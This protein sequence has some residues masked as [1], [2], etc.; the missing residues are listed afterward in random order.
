MHGW[1]QSYV[2]LGE[3]HFVSTIYCFS[4]RRH[5][6]E[7]HPLYDFF[8]FHCEGTVPHISLAYAILT[9]EKSPGDTYFVIGKEGFVKLSS[10]AYTERTY[11]KFSFESMMKVISLRTRFFADINIF[12]QNLT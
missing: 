7:K 12:R 6:S 1:C 2:H 11:G 9:G 4:F 10:K 5:L 8:K 3:V